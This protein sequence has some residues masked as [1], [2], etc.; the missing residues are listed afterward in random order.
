MTDR[1]GHGLAASTADV[2]KI[3][4]FAFMIHPIDPQRDVARKFP[5]LGKLPSGIIDYFSADLFVISG[6]QII[7]IN[8]NSTFRCGNFFGPTPFPRPF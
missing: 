4:T 3:D 6:R 7:Q 1:G 2:A 5:V 8:I